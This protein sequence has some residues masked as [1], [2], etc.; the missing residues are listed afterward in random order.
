[1]EI[2]EGHELQDYTKMVS[3]QTLTMLRAKMDEI[4]I[5]DLYGECSVSYRLGIAKGLDLV[6]D[7][8]DKYL[9]DLRSGGNED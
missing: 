1:M 9:E 2:R 3:E 6:E 8:I 7:I 5:N 4:N